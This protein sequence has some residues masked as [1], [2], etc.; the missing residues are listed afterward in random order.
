MTSKTIVPCPDINFDVDQINRDIKWLL[1]S[2]S[3]DVTKDC[4]R[5]NKN[6]KLGVNLTHPP[7]EGIALELIKGKWPDDPVKAKYLGPLTLGD[8]PA[9]EAGLD[10]SSF[11]IIGAE[12]ADKYI[13]SV[14]EQVK[15]YHATLHPELNPITRVYCAYLNTFAGYRMHMDTHTTF[16]YHLPLIEN[17]YSFMFSEDESGIEMTRLPADGRLWKLDTRKLHSAVNLAPLSNNYRMH[18]IFSVYDDPFNIYDSGV[19]RQT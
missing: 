9:A 16:K 1:D 2:L 8:K 5:D 7:M 10:T 4:F 13:G 18:I 12:I 3:F 19:Y 15:Q 6:T 11:T 17:N 14:I